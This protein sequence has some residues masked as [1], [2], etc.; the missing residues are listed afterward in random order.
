MITLTSDELKQLKEYTS[1]TSARGSAGE[2]RRRLRGPQS[3][4]FELFTQLSH[5]AAALANCPAHDAALPGCKLSLHDCSV[6]DVFYFV[7]RRR[8]SGNVTERAR[9]GDADYAPGLR[10]LLRFRVGL[11]LGLG[12][13]TML[14]AE[15][16]VFSR[17][18]SALA[19]LPRHRNGAPVTLSASL[20]IR[21]PH[22][23][24]K[25]AELV[26]NLLSSH[27][28][29]LCHGA[30]LMESRPFCF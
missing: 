6:H 7:E 11:G 25:I 24:R 18:V 16:A 12:V 3:E 10:L 22:L 2:V 28:Y 4:R 27:K 23:R 5:D 13:L 15:I 14:G 17:Q 21:H 1:G 30:A 20:D 8:S 9:S 19:L 26:C 29:F